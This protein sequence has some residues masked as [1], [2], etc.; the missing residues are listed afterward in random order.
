MENTLDSHPK[1]PTAGYVPVQ[2]LNR[3]EYAATVKAL[4]GVEVKEKEILPQDIQI[5]G[6]DNI[7]TALS[8]SPAFL[9]QYVSAARQI[10]RLAVGNPH[11]RVVSVKYPIAANENP[12]A[13]L[14][15]GTRG[16]IRFKHDFPADGEYRIDIKDLAIGP[17]PSALENQTTLAI[18]IDGRVVFRKPVGGR[19]DLALADRTAGTGRSQIMDRFTKI[20]VQVQAGVHDVVVAFVDRSHVETDENFQDLEGYNGLTGS[21]APVDRMAHLRDGVEITGPL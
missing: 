13:P 12:A 2:R 15:L 18:M 14:P 5:E 9:D 17:Y 8:V 19:E 20:P 7:A 21:Q 4:L 11:P 1:G 10:A 16:G 6:F 3:T